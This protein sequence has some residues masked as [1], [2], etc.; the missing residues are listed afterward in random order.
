VD[1]RERKGQGRLIAASGPR[2][3]KNRLEGAPGSPKSVQNGPETAAP[4]I[5][6]QTTDTKSDAIANRVL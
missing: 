5:A 1:V 2:M 4:V 6:K 3:T